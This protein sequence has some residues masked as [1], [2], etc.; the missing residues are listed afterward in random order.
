MH[1]QFEFYICLPVKYSFFK[2]ESSKFQHKTNLT[3]LN[4]YQPEQWHNM[5]D[6]HQTKIK[7]CT[8]CKLCICLIEPYTYINYK[9]QAA[10]SVSNVSM[11]YD[12]V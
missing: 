8:F 5:K 4:H 2:E 3:L 12:L 7:S 9:Q 1:K 6:L 11:L 10:L